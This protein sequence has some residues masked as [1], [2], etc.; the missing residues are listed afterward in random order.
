MTDNET[1]VYVMSLHVSLFSI[2]VYQIKH[3]NSITAWNASI[4]MTNTN[5]LII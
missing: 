3:Y 2:P 1:F 4:S 5:S